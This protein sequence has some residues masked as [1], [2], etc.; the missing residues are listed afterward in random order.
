MRILLYNRHFFPSIGG[1]EISGRI[2]ARELAGLGHAVT[3]VTATLLPDDVAEIDEGYAIVR[4]E[5]VATLVRLAR[6]HDVLFSRGGVSLRAFLAAFLGRV[7]FVA[8]HEFDAAARLAGV[9]LRRRATD[10]LKSLLRRRAAL[11]VLVSDALFNVL[12]LPPGSDCFRLYNPV[13]DE[14]WTSNPAKFVDRDLDVVFVGRLVAV[15][16]LLVLR[17]AML[18]LPERDVLRVAVVGNGDA[19]AEWEHRFRQVRGDVAFMGPLQG[20]DLRK[21]Y[22]RARIVAMP[23]MCNEGMGIVA[24]E[25]LANGTPVCASDQ[26]ALRE[27]VGDAGL[28][29]PM[30]DAGG[31]ALDVDRLLG[32]PDV[33]QVLSDRARAER[34]RFSMTQYR[35]RLA[36][37]VTQ[38]ASV[39]QASRVC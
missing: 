9:S 1:T 29:H 33:W 15:K 36:T 18:G 4:C 20:E 26:P 21:L 17:D 35:E 30:G 8:F 7:P 28:F 3:V 16:G 37:L 19:L 24:A 34:A 14:L 39:D 38:V 22:A 5:Q 31:L 32:D 11:H 27:V 25:A 6:E 13:P 10:L 12:G 2:M 23:S